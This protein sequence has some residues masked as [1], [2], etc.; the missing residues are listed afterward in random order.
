MSEETGMSDLYANVPALDPGIVY[1]GPHP[2]ERGCGV[3]IAKA[4]RAKGGA[5]WEYPEGPIYPN[6]RWRIHTCP[7]KPFV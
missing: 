3:Q 2:C 1:Y 7:N 4:E 6:T 5:E